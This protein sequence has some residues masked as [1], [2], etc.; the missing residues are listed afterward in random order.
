MRVNPEFLQRG[1]LKKQSQYA[2]LCPEIR[3]TKLEIR[4]E[5]N[6][7]QMTAPEAQFTEHLLK[8]QSQFLGME[9]SAR[10]TITR[11]YGNMSTCGGRECKANSKPNE[12]NF[13]RK[14][15]LH[16]RWDLLH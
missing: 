7:Y 14:D 3:N 6:G 13:K 8:K 10:A 11:D 2:G 12:V 5:L 16:N 9:M 15:P 4:N 1:D